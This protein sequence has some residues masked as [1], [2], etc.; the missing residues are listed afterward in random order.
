MKHGLRF[1]VKYFSETNDKKS[2][3]FVNRLCVERWDAKYNLKRNVLVTVEK[4]LFIKIQSHC[5]RANG[6]W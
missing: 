4:S 2:V 3:K 5:V 1:F 6:L